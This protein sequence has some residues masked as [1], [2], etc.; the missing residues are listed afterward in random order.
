MGG[1]GVL[2]D[3]RICL[4]GRRAELVDPE[5]AVRLQQLQFVAVGII[6]LAVLEFGAIRRGRTNPWP[7]RLAHAVMAIFFVPL[8]AT[9]WVVSTEVEWLTLSTIEHPVPAALIAEPLGTIFMLFCLSLA[10]FGAWDTMRSERRSWLLGLGL[11]VWVAASLRDLLM[12]V[13]VIDVHSFSLEY[14]F[15]AFALAL[16]GQ[17]A[18]EYTTLLSESERAR[19]VLERQFTQSETLSHLVVLRVDEGI[20]LVDGDGAIR[21]WNPA[22]ER[23]TGRPADHTLGLRYAELL[24]PGS[25]N[26]SLKKMIDRVLERQ[27]PESVDLSLKNGHQVGITIVPADSRDR[28]FIAVMRDITKERELTEHMMEM[29]RMI[30]AGSMAAGVGHEI[31]NP[32]SYVLSNL[33][34]VQGRLQELESDDELALAV[35]EAAEGG[36]RIRDV[37]SQLRAMVR[38]NDGQESVGAVP[39]RRVLTWVAKMTQSEVRSRAML[40]Q[41]A[42]DV[43]VRGVESQLG[44]VFLNLVLNAAH[45]IKPGAAAENSIRISARKVGDQVRV[46]V[47]DTGCG[48]PDREIPKIFEPFYTN[49]A[50]EQGTGLGLAISR[51]IVQQHGGRI[52]VQSKVGKGTRFV[53]LLPAA[54]TEDVSQAVVSSVVPILSRL[55]ILVV[56]DDRPVARS[57]ARLLNRE[58]EVVLCFSGKQALEEMA[59][60]PR[61]DVVLTD[62][63]MGEMDGL[64]LFEHI[65]ARHPALADHVVFMTGGL[66]TVEGQRLE[67]SCPDRVVHKPLDGRRLAK[68]LARYRAA[69]AKSDRPRLVAAGQRGAGRSVSV[70]GRS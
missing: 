39:I 19:Q 29:D 25:R 33:E 20:V 51:R 68:L 61:F 40:L 3:R 4:H 31:N 46:E 36:R 44:Q 67:L 23:I 12:M 1:R 24:P 14:G 34:F 6:S 35:S 57:L 32:L 70:P 42:D 63:M 18:A 15:L 16:V 21:L 48:I 30:T 62:I 43:A 37:V 50:P 65:K 58:H 56:D 52:E 55:R 8:V 66:L 41:E 53:V 54:A 47:V 49:K 69:R 27:I 64:A 38:P 60:D 13:H 11:G 45:A 10:T 59:K 5:E 28:S 9:H 17:H 2:G 26:H 7:R 22:M